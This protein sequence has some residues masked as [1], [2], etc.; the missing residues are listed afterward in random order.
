MP[1][2]EHA[3][4]MSQVWLA[5]HIASPALQLSGSMVPCSQGACGG[6]DSGCTQ[7]REQALQAAQQAESALQASEASWKERH[8]SL[9]V[10]LLLSHAAR[11]AVGRSCTMLSHVQSMCNAACCMHKACCR[12]MSSALGAHMLL[13]AGCTAC[14]RAASEGCRG[15]TGPAS[16]VKGACFPG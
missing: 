10:R 1:R 2:I 14:R 8:S 9:Q 4:V 16:W 6:H 7:A 15:P 12:I 13:A 11:C 5:A 3:C